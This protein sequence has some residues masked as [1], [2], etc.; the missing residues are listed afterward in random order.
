MSLTAPELGQVNSELADLAA[1]VTTTRERVAL[2]LGPQQGDEAA[3]WQE[4]AE[5]DDWM[6]WCPETRRPL[7]VPDWRQT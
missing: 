7:P 5:W 4:L 1:N 2:S 6:R 3:Y